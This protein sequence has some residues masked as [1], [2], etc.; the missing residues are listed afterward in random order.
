L[1]KRDG[2]RKVEGGVRKPGATSNYVFWRHK[3]GQC[4]VGGN[5]LQQI[6]REESQT[7]EEKEKYGDRE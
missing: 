4:V 6:Q 7:G 5:E 2:K 3:G 1:R